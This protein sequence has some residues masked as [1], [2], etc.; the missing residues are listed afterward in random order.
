M[1]K[2][3]VLIVDDS[4]VYRSQIRQAIEATGEFEVAGVAANGKIAMEK[5][6]QVE[7][8]VVTLDLEMP[9]MDGIATIRAMK[10]KKLSQR[11]IVFS[12]QSLAGAKTTLDALSLGAMDF[13][14][15]PIAANGMAIGHQLI[16]QQL[17]PI[18]RAIA[19]P[20]YVLN[21]PIAKPATTSIVEPQWK[22]RSINDMLVQALVIGSS[23]G[24][25]N[26]LENI[27]KSIR[28]HLKVPIFIVQH[29]PPVF[30]A[31]L[32]ER[33][34][35]ISGLDVREAKDNESVVSGRVYVAPGDFHMRIEKDPLRI[36]LHQGPKRQSVRPACDELFESAAQIYGTGCLAVVLTGMG[37][38]GTAGAIAVKQ[39]NGAV[40]IQN[41]ESC[42][43]YG[44][45]GAVEKAQAFDRIADLTEISQ[46]LNR[47]VFRGGALNVS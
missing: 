34:K 10:D 12:A 15:K 41:K 8:D 7:A 18:L 36:V 28:G 29:M 43:V 24:G 38:D 35:Q 42:A 20:S 23:T 4:A 40:M 17:L 21:E 25:P 39:N 44:M 26:A 5:L 33:L 19:K 45:P 47:L 2:L 37:E 1:K 14:P 16:G 30:T 13:V 32:A 6:F 11:I 9:E 22:S 27:F 31:T 46:V 3:R